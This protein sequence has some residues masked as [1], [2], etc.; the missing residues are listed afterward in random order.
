MGSRKWNLLNSIPRYKLLRNKNSKNRAQTNTHTHSHNQIKQLGHAILWQDVGSLSTP[1][2]IPFGQ[3][4]PLSPST[5]R[6]QRKQTQ[7][8]SKRELNGRCGARNGEY[9]YRTHIPSVFPDL[10][11]FHRTY[12]FKNKKYTKRI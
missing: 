4:L 10:L 11:I 8:Q 2:S 5:L 7:K 12:F 9:P 3:L 1:S 6:T